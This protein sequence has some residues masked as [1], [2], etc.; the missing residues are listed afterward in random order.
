MLGG[1]FETAFAGE[2]MTF[3]RYQGQF[4]IHPPARRRVALVGDG[5]VGMWT[6]RA[7]ERAGCLIVR[8]DEP[9][10]L[11]VVIDGDTRHPCWEVHIDGAAPQRVG[12]LREVAMLVQ[13][14]QVHR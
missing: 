6:S 1:A 3:D 14:S 13:Q 9:A 12:S 4:H 10:S 7:L 5:L 11:R 2:G 8:S